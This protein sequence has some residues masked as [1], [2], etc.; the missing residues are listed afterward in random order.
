VDLALGFFLLLRLR[1]RRR[2]CR[3]VRDSVTRSTSRLTMRMMSRGI[4][5]VSRKAFPFQTVT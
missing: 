2:N 4:T 3:G 5:V 1:S